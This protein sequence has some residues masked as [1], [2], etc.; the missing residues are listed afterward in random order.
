MCEEEM[1]LPRT[2]TFEPKLGT[3]AFDTFAGYL[4]HRDE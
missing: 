3:I 4:L 1:S 2:Q